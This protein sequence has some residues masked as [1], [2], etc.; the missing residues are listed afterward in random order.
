MA[1]CGRFVAFHG[2]SQVRI[3]H[4]ER[5][6]CMT[7]SEKHDLLEAVCHAVEERLKDL[8]VKHCNGKIT[9]EAFIESVLEIEARDVTPQGLTLTA[10]HTR[11]DWTV[12]SIKINGMNETCA[13]FEFLPE[14]GEFR[15]AKSKCDS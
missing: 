9:D 13:A 3:H 12:F 5:S 4:S 7:A 6:V 14:T 11:D 2:I 10:S 15:R 1:V 8:A